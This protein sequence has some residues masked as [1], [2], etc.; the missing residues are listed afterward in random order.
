MKKKQIIYLLFMYVIFQ[1]LWWE[2]LLVKLHYENFEKQKQLNALRIT[3]FNQFKKVENKLNKEQ[4]MKIIMVVGE[5]TVFLVLILFGFYRVLKAYEK[6][7]IVSQRQTNFLLALPHEIKTP[8]SI[9][10]LNL[11]TLMQNKEMENTQKEIFIQKSLK[12]LKRLHNLIEQ[13]LLSSKIMKSKYALDIKKVLLSEKL[14]EWINFYSEQKNIQQNIHANIYVNA[15][16]NL[17][18]L[19]I[20]NLLDNAVKF[21]ENYIGVKLY[22]NN[23]QVFL[24]IENDGELIEKHEKE[25]IFELFYRRKSDEE[26]G[27]KG[28]GLGLYLVKQIAELHKI[29]INVL[30]KNNYNVFQVVF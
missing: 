17:L 22:T 25:K 21:S 28:T 3:D 8:L 16:E 29:K 12:E 27:I 6:E 30:I 2:I 5:G 11:Q 26:K 10:Q 24:E 14:N 20:Q 9:M 13:L 1:F 7:I 15:D 18:Q 4:R 23:N 19:M